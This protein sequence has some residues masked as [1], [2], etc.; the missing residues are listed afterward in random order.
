MWAL[1]PMPWVLDRLVAEAARS[2]ELR[3]ELT[4]VCM[5]RNASDAIVAKDSAHSSFL[6]REDGHFVKSI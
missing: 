3:V 6:R 5:Q 2:C 4:H 1:E